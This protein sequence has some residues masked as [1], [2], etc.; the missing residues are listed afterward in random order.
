MKY[1]IVLGILS[2]IFTAYH[3]YVAPQIDDDGKV[4]KPGKKI[5]DIFK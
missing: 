4:T 5:R 1:I 3:M 2:L